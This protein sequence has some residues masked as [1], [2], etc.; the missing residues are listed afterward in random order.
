MADA[1][2]RAQFRLLDW[3]EE[4]VRDDPGF[5]D[6]E[7]GVSRLDAFFVHGRGGLRFTE[8]N[9]ETPAGAAYNDVLSEVFLGLPVMREFLRRFEVRPLPARH[10]C[11]TRCSTP[12]TSGRGRRERRASASWTGARCPPTASS[13]SPRLLPL[14]GASSA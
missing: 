2:F 3:E 10:T 5:R 9:A 4:L 13:C 6:A 14:A 8:Y 12:T 1:A 11:C 7:P